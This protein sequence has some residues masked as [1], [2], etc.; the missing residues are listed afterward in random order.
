MIDFTKNSE[1]INLNRKCC[2]SCSVYKASSFQEINQN[3]YDKF[4]KKDKVFYNRIGVQVILNLVDFL[5]LTL[6]LFRIFL[7]LISYYFH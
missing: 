4:Y 6:T 1:G 7:G 2:Q 5:F 3:K